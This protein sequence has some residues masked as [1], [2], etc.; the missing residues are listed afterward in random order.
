MTYRFEEHTADVKFVV[1]S[2]DLG[3]L[4]LE[5]ARA[6]KENICGNIKVLEQ[7]EK[8]IVIQGR[9]LE[10]LLYKFLEEF[11]VLL[12]SESFLVSSVSNI[13]LDPENFSLKAKIKGDKSEKYHFTN[14]VKAI[15]YSQMEITKTEEG[16]KATVVLDV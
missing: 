12:D 2:K 10:N 14:D 7:I 8:D 6:L 9:N 16:F 5:G 15:T 11:L 1:E 13:E 3:E 4:F